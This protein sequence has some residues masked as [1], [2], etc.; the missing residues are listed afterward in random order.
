MQ[1]VGERALYP[2][3]ELIMKDICSR[4]LHWENRRC[5]WPSGTVA[6]VSRSPL[7]TT[8]FPPAAFSSN[9]KHFL[10]QLHLEGPRTHRPGCHL[11]Q[12]FLPCYDSGPQPPPHPW[13]G[14]QGMQG[15]REN[16]QREMRIYLSDASEG[17]SDSLKHFPLFIVSNSL[18]S[19]FSGIFVAARFTSALYSTLFLMFS[20]WRFFLSLELLHAIQ[21]FL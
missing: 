1:C 20:H 14:A 7:T 10:R 13:E 17:H 12:I 4:E 16:C 11:T 5:C 3:K 9:R 15:I 21:A 19:I 6:P 2:V 8:C 18:P